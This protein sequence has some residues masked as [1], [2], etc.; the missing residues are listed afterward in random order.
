MPFSRSPGSAAAES[1]G[2]VEANGDR[3]APTSGPV[4]TSGAPVDTS[5]G[6]RLVL[7]EHYFAA[8]W[9]LVA[10]GDLAGAKVAHEAAGRLLAGATRGRS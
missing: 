2:E 9:E 5:D 4:D 3:P 1:A 10:A 8:A 6:A 7:L